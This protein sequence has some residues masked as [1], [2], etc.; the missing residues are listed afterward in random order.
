MK[1]V[2]SYIFL[3]F[4]FQINQFVNAQVD[5]LDEDSIPAQIPENLDIYLVI[6]QSNMAGRAT[7]REEDNAS[8]ENAYLFTGDDEAPWLAA[9]NPLNRYSTMRKDMKMQRLS[10]AFSF[11]RSIAADHTD[12]EIALVMNARGGTKIVQWLPGTELYQEAIKQ[13]H[14]A[15]NYGKLKG[16]IWHQ[17]EGDCDPLRVDMYLGR[18]EML[19]FG[20]RDEFD[21]PT[22]PLIAGQVYENENRHAFNEMILQLPDFI[23][24]T[25]VATSEGTSTKDGT[26][27]N[28]ESAIIMG[29]R[30]AVEMKKIQLELKK[31]K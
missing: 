17:G 18:L 13:T 23:R 28:S 2:K 27:F 24:Y 16:I 1:V 3:L 4:L 6:G 25:G 31:K 11:V 20:I 29:D 7:I 15:L 14:R 26:H 12:N 10:P 21:D 5:V 9:T 30:Y 22:I 8:I 19:I